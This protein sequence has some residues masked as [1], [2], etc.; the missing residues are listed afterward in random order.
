MREAHARRFKFAHSMHAWLM[1][2]RWYT[3]GQKA[4]CSLWNGCWKYVCTVCQCATECR[5]AQRQRVL[6]LGTRVITSWLCVFLCN[7]FSYRESHCEAESELYWKS[8]YWI[9]KFPRNS[10]KLNFQFQENGFASILMKKDNHCRLPIILIFSGDESPIVRV[11]FRATEA[12][13]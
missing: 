7:L 9:S 12:R 2:R 11:S 8:R 10:I 4:A 1:A 13:F 5:R 3:Y 6:S